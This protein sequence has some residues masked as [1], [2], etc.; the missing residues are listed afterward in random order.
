MDRMTIA[1]VYNYLVKQGRLNPE[2]SISALVQEWEDYLKMAKRLKMD[3]QNELFYKPRNIKEAHDK[4]IALMEEKGLSIKA[5]EIAD[6]YPNIEDI[7][8]EINEK[9]S[10]EDKKYALVIPSRIEDML[11]E[12]NALSLCMDRDDRYFERISVRETYIAFLRRKSEPDKPWYVIEFEPNG[13]LRQESTAGDRKN[14]DFDEAV[15]FCKKWQRELTKRLT[16]EDRRLAEQSAQLRL[17]EWE[18]LRKNK[19]KIRNGPLQGK[20]LVNVLEQRLM[21]AEVSEN[22]G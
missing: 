16:E 8:A 20:L 15:P 3:V 10:F 9:Y 4:V 7:L 12:S 2:E 19:N 1:K 22:V 18:E 5:S 6:K 14:K 13:T 11:N 17:K 21:E